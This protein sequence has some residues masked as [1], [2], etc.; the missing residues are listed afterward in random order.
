M[1]TRETNQSIRRFRAMLLAAA[2]SMSIG[3][4][5]CT[6]QVVATPQ[7]DNKRLVHTFDFDER[8]D[9]NLEAIP[10]Y[11]DQVRMFGFPGFADGAFDVE[12]GHDA[13]PSFH[14]NSNGRNVAYEYDGPELAIRTAGNYRVTAFVL[15]DRLEHGRACLAAFFRD[16]HGN[17]MLETLV[18]TPYIRSSQNQDEWRRVE[19]L[20]PVASPLATH[21]GLSVWVLQEE[22]WSTGPSTAR[23]IRRVDVHGGVWID[24]I[25]VV[26]LPR[27]RMETSTPGN[28]L[29]AGDPAEL[30]IT[31]SDYQ[32]GKM[33]AEIVVRDAT[34]SEVQKHEQTIAV[35][36]Q[37]R[38]VVIPIGKLPAGLYHAT[39]SL[40]ADGASVLDRRIDFVRL[41]PMAKLSSRGT[42]TLGISIERSHRSDPAIELALLQRQ[43]ARAV[44]IPVWSG[45]DDPVRG[46]RKARARDTLL[47]ELTTDGFMLTAVLAALPASLVVPNAPYANSIL[48]I[49]SDDPAMWIR[50][51]AAVAAPYANTYRWWQVGADAQPADRLGDDYP[52]AV[53]NVREALRPYLLLPRMTAAISYANDPASTKLPVEQATIVIAPSVATNGIA[54]K[55]SALRSQGYEQVSALVVPH[56]SSHFDRLGRLANFAQRVLTARHGG[57]NVVYTPPTWRVRDTPFGAV[58]EPQEEFIL[59]R[60]I[61]ELLGDAQPGPIV[62]MTDD[63]ECLAFYKTGGSATLVLWDPQAPPEGREHA[64]QLGKADRVFDL[65]GRSQ[66]LTRDKQ[67]RHRLRLTNLPVFVP[68]VER[69]LIDFRSSLAI[70]PNRIDPGQELVDHKIAASYFGAT[71]VTGRASLRVPDSWEVTPRSFPISYSSQQPADIEQTIH[72]TH[73]ENSGTKEIVARI[74]LETSKYYLEIPLAVDIELDALEVRGMATIEGE[75]LVVRHLVNNKTDQAVNFR[76]SVA[77]PGKMRQYRPFT[78]IAPGSTQLV[79]Y[80]FRDA[81]QLAGRKIHLA[82]REMR[83]DPRVHNLELTVP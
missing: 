48:D 70:T 68:G 32:R 23:V 83:D 77:V 41:A 22:K 29:T 36:G 45:L 52:K 62:P 79:E 47:Q 80:R 56:E 54:A 7:P 75:T 51:L 71:P 8:D 78:N 59:V 5:F 28:V 35:D 12:V 73:R 9:G 55:I 66:I 18:R 30:V 49:L 3:A 11:W 15:P 65:W 69:W 57:A 4:A 44:K 38:R 26:T 53:I 21:I 19:L 82:L 72:Y 31:I 1:R 20:L 58:T 10:K 74:L 24:D 50:Q 61:A 40:T 17:P 2:F 25:T 16:R 81:S 42:T 67:G 76:S 43:L 13:S 33:T 6:A 37:D 14:L 39:L 63:V 64:I 27:V 60:T 34:G 46:S